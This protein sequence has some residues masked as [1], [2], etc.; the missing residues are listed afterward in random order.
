MPSKFMSIV[1]RSYRPL[2]FL[3]ATHNLQVR[4]LISSP[5][6]YPAQTRSKSESKAFST[7]RAMSSSPP[8]NEWLVHVPDHPNALEK[9]LAVRQEHLSK[10][11]PKI[12]G[13]TVVFGGATLSQHPS[14]GE[15]PDMTGSVMLIKA[16]TKEEVLE[17]LEN[18]TY[19]KGGAWNPKEAKIW[20]FRCAVRT[21]L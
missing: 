9:R 11:K 7:T 10:L 4:V 19:T 21:A 16:N 15:A 20:P 6:I 12:E 1:S 8:T 2:A 18:D 5:T 17:F 13:G 14:E 3:R